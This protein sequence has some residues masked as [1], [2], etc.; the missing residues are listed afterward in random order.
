VIIELNLDGLEW[1]PLGGVTPVQIARILFTSLTR[2]ISECRGFDET[3]RRG[4]VHIKCGSKIEIKECSELKL[5]PNSNS[6]VHEFGFSLIY[7]TLI[8]PNGI[9]PKPRLLDIAMCNPRQKL[10]LPAVNFNPP[11]LII[12]QCKPLI[13][14]IARTD[15][16]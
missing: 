12:R 16:I 11:I 6:T 10:I 3:S 15:C 5:K 4:L 14:P 1:S 7:L 13:A 9:H 2:E 8:I